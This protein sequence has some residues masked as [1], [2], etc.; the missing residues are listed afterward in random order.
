MEVMS[1]ETT[2]KL[3][4]ESEG[5]T[6]KDLNSVAFRAEITINESDGDKCKTN[7]VETNGT[8]PS[9]SVLRKEAV[10]ERLAERR[11]SLVPMSSMEEENLRERLHLAQLKICSN[12][13]F[14]E[15]R[16]ARDSF[17]RLFQLKVI[18]FW[19]A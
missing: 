1:S 12:I 13:I 14:E 10:D 7:G 19:N 17:K 16:Y 11:R 18:F 6:H 8:T 5:S 15:G 3:Q 4:K 9:I 2:P